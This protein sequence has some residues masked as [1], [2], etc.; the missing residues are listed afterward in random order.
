MKY[1]TPDLFRRTNS[2]DMDESVAASDVWEQNL[3]QYQRRLKTIRAQLPNA[4]LEFLDGPS[5]HDADVLDFVQSSVPVRAG[6]YPVVWLFVRQSQRF[7]M[8]EY[9]LMQPPVVERRV[10]PASLRCE[11]ATWLYD[12]IDVVQPDAYSH[13]IFISTGNVIK[14]VFTQFKLTKGEVILDQSEERFQ[15]AA[16]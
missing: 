3:L 6:E 2:P 8:L 5:L 15:G 7:M 12:E 9:S 16:S 4:V 10:L 14:L 13:E 1:F 11:P